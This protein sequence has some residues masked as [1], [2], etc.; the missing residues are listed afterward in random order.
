[1]A[2]IENCVMILQI[3]PLL[4]FME[5]NNTRV[6]KKLGNNQLIMTAFHLQL[7]YSRIALVFL[8]KKCSEKDWFENVVDISIFSIDSGF[9]YN[10]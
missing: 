9:L 1:M 2:T 3:I 8:K 4:C 6:G 10:R 7:S 5:N